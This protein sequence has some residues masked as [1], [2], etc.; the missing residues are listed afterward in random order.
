MPR[1]G[2]AHHNV[3]LRYGPL[4]AAGLLT[5]VLLALLDTSPDGTGGSELSE[6]LERA[7]DRRPR[8]DALLG[9]LLQLEASG[10]VLVERGDGR[11]LFKL[12]DRGRDRS[13]ELG[14]GRP[15]HVQ[16]LM[17]DL[18]DFVAVTSA[19]GD[20]AARD[21]AGAL[22]QAAEAAVGAAGGAVVKALGDGFLAWL[23]P[24][25]DPAPV[26]AAIADRCVLPSGDPWPLRAASHVGSP[27]RHGTD[28]FGGDVNL[29]SRLCAVAE[30][31]QLLRTDPGG[32]GTEAVTIRGLTEPVDVVRTAIR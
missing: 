2:P 19:H 27:I 13:Y 9:A 10:L 8:A 18:V 23:P 3:V 20:G 15:V 26:V 16:L 17:A 22:L 32:P 21:A 4:V 24:I 5:D 6:R 12:T 11:H 7:T 29:V 30:P 14:G 1:A 31:D 28:L 25:T